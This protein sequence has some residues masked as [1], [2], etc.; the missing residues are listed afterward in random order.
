MVKTVEILDD[1]SI[2]ER[3]RQLR[4]AH[5]GNRGKA[6]FAKALGL[7]P[8]TYNYYE[9]DRLPPIDVL[10]SICRTTGADLQWLLTGEK[11]SSVSEIPSPLSEKIARCL[12]SDPNAGV[13][14]S[15]FLDLLG[16]KSRVEQGILAEGRSRETTPGHWLPILGRTAAGFI[17]FWQDEGD[18]LPGITELSELIDK[19]KQSSHRRLQTAGISSDAARLNLPDITDSAVSMIQLTEV[20]EEG[21]SEFIDCGAIAQGYPGAFGLRVDGDSMAPRIRD[22]DIVILHPDIPARDGMTAVVKLRD[23]IG[24]S[25][26]IIRFDGA[27]VHLIAIQE[28]YDTKIYPKDQVFWA[29]AVLWRIRL[30]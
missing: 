30:S 23:Q 9:K 17:Q 19:H 16:Q 25:C 2:I 13:V 8:S 1:Q 15:S 26:K 20:N 6:I 5:A 29:L 10:W 22:G 4:Q 3:I 24:T 7:S 11:T 21:I 27:Q 12:Q 14:L 28:R 18:K